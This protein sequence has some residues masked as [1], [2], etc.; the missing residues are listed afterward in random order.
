V[1]TP[2]PG[3]SEASDTRLERGSVLRI[4]DSKSPL[5]H[6]AVAAAPAIST[7]WNES[8]KERYLAVKEALD[9]LGVA[10]VENARLVRG[11]DYYDHTAFEFKLRD[12]AQGQDTVMAGGHYGGLVGSLGGPGS[13]AGVG[14]AAGV[15]RLIN[16]LQDLHGDSL[17]SLPWIMGARPALVAVVALEGQ[18]GEE[19]R[20]SEREAARRLAR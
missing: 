19:H 12:A 20:E 1:Q 9:E 13:V 16:L 14:W 7:S 2:A 5:D 4:L 6:A 17:E 11:L 10:Y 18:E 3:L 8:S 15:E